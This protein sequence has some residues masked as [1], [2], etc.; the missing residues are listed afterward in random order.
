MITNQGNTPLSAR[1]STLTRGF[2]SQTKEIALQQCNFPPTTR[3]I[4]HQ[5]R[6]DSPRKYLTRPP[7]YLNEPQ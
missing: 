2:D 5:R 1:N 6:I 3:E 4:G 7:R